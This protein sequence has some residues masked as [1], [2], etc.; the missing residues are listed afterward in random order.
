MAAGENPAAPRTYSP[1]A[2]AGIRSDAEVWMHGNVEASRELFDSHRDYARL[3]TPER[4][5]TEAAD[6]WHANNL[7][8]RTAI[9]EVMRELGER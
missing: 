6:A 3:L 9:H 5:V 2:E 7:L 1:A 4:R 8:K